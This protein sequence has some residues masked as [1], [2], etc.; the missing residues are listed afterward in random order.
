VIDGEGWCKPV[1]GTNWACQYKYKSK[2]SLCR[3]ANGICDAPD[4]CEYSCAAYVHACCSVL[5]QQYGSNSVSPVNCGA[6]LVHE[7]CLKL[8]IRFTLCPSVFSQ[9]T[10]PHILMHPAQA[11]AAPPLALTL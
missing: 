3:A 11:L 6:R 5:G 8:L 4:M 9:T 10:R 2:G 7:G 1:D